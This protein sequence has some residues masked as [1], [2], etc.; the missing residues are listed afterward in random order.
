LSQKVRRRLRALRRYQRMGLKAKIRYAERLIEAALLLTDRPIVCWSGGK[1]STVL[2]HLTRKLCPDIAVMFNDSGVEFPETIDFVHRLADAW[3]LN[4]H[5]T[6]PP[7]GTF[8]RCV[9]EYGW[10]IGGKG[11]EGIR[12]RAAQ[13]G[14]RTSD[15]CAYYCKRKP[16]EKLYKELG[17]DCVLTGT[18]AGESKRRRFLWVDFGDLYYQTRRQLWTVHPL[19]I[20]LD[21]D[22]WAYHRRYALPHNPLYDMGHARVGC[23]SCLMDWGYPD[24]HLSRLR[25]SHP[26]LWR[27]LVVDR[28][29]G[30]ELLKLRLALTHGQADLF[31]ATWTIEELVE[32]YPGFFDII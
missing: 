8:W 27:H 4:L 24:S 1:D 30:Q 20:W 28:G 19:A 5:V 29:L 13:A 23:W 7:P 15:N 21:K 31:S 25:R 9:E 6:S 11:K 2:L 32:I 14:V 16:A 17:I 26:K 10:P 3:R 18:L 12:K 22:I